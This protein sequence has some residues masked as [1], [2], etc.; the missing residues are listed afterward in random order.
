MWG[1]RRRRLLPGAALLWICA[2]SSLAAPASDARR[3]E[4]QQAAEAKKAAA[5]TAKAKEAGA[6]VSTLSKHLAGIAS[7]QA[8]ASAARSQAEN[9]L[10]A[11]RTQAEADAEALARDRDALETLLIG[12]IANETTASSG[13]LLKTPARIEDGSDALTEAMAKSMAGFFTHAVARHAADRRDQIARADALSELIS[14][15]RDS[16]AYRESALQEAGAKTEAKLATAARQRD[17]FAAQAEA[18]SARSRALAAQAKD[19]RDLAA[20]AAV[21]QKRSQNKVLAAPA[22]GPRQAPA[23]G[24][25]LIRFGARTKSGAAAQGLTLRTAP[26]AKV[27]APA[28]AT[29]TFS[30]PFR[31]Y[32]RVL[33][34]D[35][36]NGYAMILT[37]LDS[38]FVG[39]GDKVTAG[40][41]IGQMGQPAA[42]AA[43]APELYFEV[44]QAG[45][46]ID[47]ERWLHPAG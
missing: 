40:T 43:N 25:V 9:E 8:A 42:G 18:A 33:I 41:L 22:T 26:G 47:P 34:L 11:V 14:L 24:N 30:G 46:P 17:A 10:D 15:K 19:L 29:I 36:G 27:V 23:A 44:R 3:L 13:P 12:L 5:L 35:Q 20:R 32:G 28:Q 37:G 39:A 31:S 21:A 2:A 45:R 6:Q 1:S 7:D 4:R 16:L 38:A